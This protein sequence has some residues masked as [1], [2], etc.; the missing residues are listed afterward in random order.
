MNEVRAQANLSKLKIHC[1][2][3]IE[4]ETNEEG[5]EKKISSSNHRVD[6][7]GTRLREP[8]PSSVLPLQPYIIGLVGGI[9]S[10]KSAICKHFEKLGAIVINCD[11][12]AH[13]MY[14]PGTDCYSEVCRTFGE[15]ILN[16]D[17]TINR[18]VLGGLVFGKPDQLQKLNNIVWPSLLR[19]VKIIIQRIRD[20]NP[21]EQ[22]VVMIEAAVLLQA[23]WQDE[24]H[25]IWS[26]IIPPEE[27]S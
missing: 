7:L 26:L 3:L 4:L 9:A 13:D 23:G 11:R 14:K 24:L 12:M 25:E 1:I 20:E 17:R 27:V 5:K 21:N 15:E 16:E 6:L 18:K 19:E 2:D 10:G 22:K 8:K